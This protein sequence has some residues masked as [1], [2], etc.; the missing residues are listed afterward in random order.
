LRFS[1]RAEEAIPMHERAIRLDPMPPPSYLYMLGLCYALT[2]DPGKGI[3]ICKKA[4][5]QNPD[6]LAVHLALAVAY[7]LGGN[8]EEARAEAAEVL[9]IHPKF[10]VDYAA[11]TWPY[12]NK[13]DIDLVATALRKAGLK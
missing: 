11:K 2:R 8:E 6:D 1:G 12:K 13:A 4:L 3:S 7:S 5:H 10:S 9:R